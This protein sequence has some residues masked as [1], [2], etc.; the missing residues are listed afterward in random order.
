MLLGY[1]TELK[2]PYLS[3]QKVTEESCGPSIEV[4][5]VFLSLV[6]LGGTRYVY[7]EQD[8]AHDSQGNLV[9][10]YLQYERP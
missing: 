6:N 1:Q 5:Q 9:N 3:N 2:N 7:E 4:E 10:P 8:S